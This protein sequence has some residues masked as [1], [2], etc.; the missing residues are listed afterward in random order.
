MQENYR[1]MFLKSKNIKTIEHI[2]KETDILNHR[3]FYILWQIE[4]LAEKKDISKI[5]KL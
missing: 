4:W 5:K 3:M 2:K 1:N